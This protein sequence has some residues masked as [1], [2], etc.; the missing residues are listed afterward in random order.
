M[1]VDSRSSKHF[2][3]L[4]LI[5]GVKSKMLEYREINPPMEIKPAG[6]NTF[7]GTAQGVLLVLVRDTQDAC[8]TVKVSIVLVPGLGTFFFLWPWQLLGCQ[9]YFH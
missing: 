1:L 7:F 8:R 4:K 3:D 6:H 2:V 9:N 5:P